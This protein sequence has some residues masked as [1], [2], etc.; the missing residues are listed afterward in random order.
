MN[1][2]TLIAV[3]TGILSG[4]FSAGVIAEP[5]T[6]IVDSSHTFPAF[7]ADHWGGLSI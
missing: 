5:V 4:V 6:Y 3:S 7:E 2:A 1:K